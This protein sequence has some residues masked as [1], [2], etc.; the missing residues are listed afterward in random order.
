MKTYTTEEGMVYCGTCGTCLGEDPIPEDKEC[1]TCW[2]IENGDDTGD[3]EED[4]SDDVFYDE[5]G[6]A[7]WNDDGTPFEIDN[8]DD[9]EDPNDSRNL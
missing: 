3:D 7:T 4:W 9:N 6:E 2:Q 8:D 5:N 1:G